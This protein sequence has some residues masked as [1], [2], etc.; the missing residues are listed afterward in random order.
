MFFISFR[1]AALEDIWVFGGGSAGYVD[2]FNED[3]GSRT[4]KAGYQLSAEGLV[5]FYWEDFVL[6]GGAGWL[7]NHVSGYDLSDTLFKVTTK[8]GYAFGSL[9]YRFLPRVSAG[10]VVHVIFGGGDVSFSETSNTKNFAL[11]VGLQAFYELPVKKARIRFGGSILTDATIMHRQLMWFMGHLQFGFSL[12]G[13]TQSPAPAARYSRRGDF[14]VMGQTIRLT[15]ADETIYF[16]TDKSDITSQT[17]EALEAIA[18]YLVNRTTDWRMIQVDG[19]ADY[20]GSDKY[21][22]NLSLQ[23]AAR[24][25]ETLISGGVPNARVG[26]KAF[27]ETRAAARGTS[28]EALSKNRRVELKINGV[29]NPEGMAGELNAIWSDYFGR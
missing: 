14:E 19:H 12:S 3:E 17:R 20:R 11:A 28:P 16:D 27:G 6:D 13:D 29:T 4:D 18:K 1:A 5:A 10:P 24:V 9:R 7:Y 26:F 22:T 21:N 15:L 2:L 25:G 23:R 8:A